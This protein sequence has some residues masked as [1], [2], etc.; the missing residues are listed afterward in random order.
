MS[1]IFRLGAGDAFLPAAARLAFNSD[2]LHLQAGGRRL[3]FAGCCQAYFYFEIFAF[4]CSF[5][6]LRLMLLAGTCRLLSAG[7]SG[8]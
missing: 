8:F 3:L 4:L 5:P 2:V 7:F 1:S 6:G